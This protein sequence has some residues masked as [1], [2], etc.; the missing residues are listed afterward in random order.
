MSRSDIKEQI[1]QYMDE[2]NLDAASLETDLDNP[3]ISPHV[4]LVNYDALM[5]KLCRFALELEKRR[6]QVQ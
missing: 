5:T 2:L 1:G 6:K 4:R 3:D